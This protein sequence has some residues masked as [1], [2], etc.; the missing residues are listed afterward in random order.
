MSA[1]KDSVH[2]SGSALNSDDKITDRHIYG[3]STHRISMDSAV[4]EFFD[5]GNYKGDATTPEELYGENSELYN[6]YEVD[7]LKELKQEALDAHKADPSYENT[8]KLIETHSILS[9]RFDVINIE[10]MEAHEAA[11]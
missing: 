3:S 2:A 1:S 10:R 6:M 11:L 7:Y 5:W 4:T 9:D 8:E